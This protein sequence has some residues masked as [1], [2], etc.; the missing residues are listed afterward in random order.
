M[1]KALILFAFILVSACLLLPK[2]IAPKHQEKV[3]ELIDIIDKTPGYSAQIISTDFAWFGS[4]NKVI[5]S[6]DMAQIDASLSEDKVQI[7]LTIDTHYG[8]LL[9]SGQGLL[10]AYETDIRLEGSQQRTL[11]NWDEDQPLY[12]LSVL[13]GISGNIKLADTVPMLSNLDNTFQF[14]GY[15][16]TGALTS[17]SFTYQG[18]LK[19]MEIMGDYTSIN[20]EDFALEMKIDSGLKDITKG[21]F[22]DSTTN[23]SLNKL[24]IDT[25]TMLSGLAI[26]MSSNLDPTTQ[27]GRI[28]IAYLLKE[29]LSG[30]MKANDLMLVTELNKLSNAFFLEYKAFSDQALTNHNAAHAAYQSLFV[31]LQDN[32]DTLLAAKPEFN[33]TD[34][35]GTFP[36]GRF[37]ASLTSTLGDIGD[38]SVEELAMAEFW[39]YHTLVTANIEVD[40][41]LLTSVAERFIAYQMRAPRNAPEIKQ[42]ARI[43]I[44]NLLQQGLIRLDNGRYNTVINIQNGQGSINNMTFP[45]M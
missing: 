27:L 20:A 37:E 25:N 5:L 33:I 31:F 7:E 34:L 11:F 17:D 32:I 43:I 35:S 19:K 1:K 18:A 16:G 6:L 40:E 39:L 24:S 3:V 30:D 13:G 45:L 12:L 23:L 36:E 29:F 28:E 9:L 38:A 4:E 26:K 21:G 22:Y 41:V 44:N 14:S 10:G 2:F 42:Q 8:P 15:T